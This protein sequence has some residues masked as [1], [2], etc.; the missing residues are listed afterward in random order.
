LHPWKTFAPSGIAATREAL[1]VTVRKISFFTDRIEVIA[2]FA[3]GGQGF[4]TSFPYGR[5]I[6]RDERSRS[7]RPMTVTIFDVELQ[8]GLHLAA[9]A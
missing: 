7:Y 3:N 5:S 8:K 6:L 4:V 9:G 1:T 2:T